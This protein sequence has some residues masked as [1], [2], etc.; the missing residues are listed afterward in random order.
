MPKMDAQ[1]SIQR[2]LEVLAAMEPIDRRS[3]ALTESA[4]HVLGLCLKLPAAGC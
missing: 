4:H 2:V 3:L 1:T